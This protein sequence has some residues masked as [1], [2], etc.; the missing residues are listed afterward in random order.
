[1]QENISKE[2][3]LSGQTLSQYLLAIKCF[4]NLSYPR[5]CSNCSNHHLNGNMILAPKF[6]LELLV[7]AEAPP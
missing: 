1:M 4:I 5:P 3:Q 2:S 6:L 7:T